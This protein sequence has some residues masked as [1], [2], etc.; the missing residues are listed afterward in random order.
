[1][2]EEC[3]TTHDHV[4]F[5]GS[6]DP[7][8]VYEKRSKSRVNDRFDRIFKLYRKSRQDLKKYYASKNL[9]VPETCDQ[10]V[11]VVPLKL[12]CVTADKDDLGQVII[13]EKFCFL[14]EFATKELSTIRDILQ[15][16]SLTK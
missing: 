9:P 8:F 4:S 15:G 5:S 10:V 6:L 16:K 12:L 1:M 7:I 11:R 2:D 14:V 13:S 3:E